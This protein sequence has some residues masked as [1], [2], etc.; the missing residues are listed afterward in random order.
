M[1]LDN[2]A[3][4]AA[5]DLLLDHR[6]RRATL[7]ALPRALRPSD[8]DTAYAIQD[9][10]ITKRCHDGATKP[11]GYKIGATNQDARA[12]LGVDT[13]FFGVLL[14]TM[15]SQAPA[16]FVGSDWFMRVIEPEIAFADLEDNM[17]LAEDYL[18]FCVQFVLDNCDEDLQFFEEKKIDENLRERLRNVVAEPFQRMTYTEAID[19]LLAHKRSKKAKFN[20]K[21]EKKDPLRWGIDLRSEHERYLTEQVFKKPVIVTDYPASFKAFYMRLNDDGK[22]RV[23]RNGSGWRL[24]PHRIPPSAPAEARQPGSVSAS[25]AVT[26]PLCAASTWKSSLP[27][28]W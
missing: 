1:A 28:H 11:I 23:G 3:I 4:D 8:T 18:K 6:R 16:T 19:L 13:P 20:R 22:R 2:T 15:T 5:A 24:C 7:S 17:N 9:A 25:S 12:M 10:V 21:A 14:S 26:V 27:R